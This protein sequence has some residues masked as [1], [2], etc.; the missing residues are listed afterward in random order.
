MYLVYYYN[1][2]DL[3]S[4]LNEAQ[5]IAREYKSGKVEPITSINRK[6]KDM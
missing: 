2:R 1:K 5:Q 4:R 6:Y 3:E